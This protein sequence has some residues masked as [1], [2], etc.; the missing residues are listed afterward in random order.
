VNRTTPVDK[1]TD[2]PTDTRV[3]F[4]MNDDIVQESVGDAPILLTQEGQASV[5]GEGR[6]HADRRAFEYMVA[7]RLAPGVTYRAVLK[8]GFRNRHDQLFGKDH[9]ITFTTAR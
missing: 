5:P 9:V 6:Y 8:S 7:G 4:A 3:T 1:A 2:V